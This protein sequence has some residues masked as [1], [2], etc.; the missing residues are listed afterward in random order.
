[1]TQLPKTSPDLN[2]EKGLEKGEDYGEEKVWSGADHRDA[3][4]VGGIRVYRLKFLP[5][6]FRP[7]IQ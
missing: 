5:Q 2:S 7:E 6:F 3:S 1:M 4:G